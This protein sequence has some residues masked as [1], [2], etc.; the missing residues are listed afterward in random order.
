MKIYLDTSNLEEIHK[1]FT[2]GVVDG[3]TTNPSLIKAERDRIKAKGEPVEMTD[4]LKEI[5]ET[6]GAN[7][8]VSLEVIGSTYDEFVREG[9][10]LFEKFNPVAGNVVVKIPINPV[11]GDET[12]GNV[13]D[14]LKAIHHFS[15]QKVPV[16]CTLIFTP[17]QALLA[18]KAGA[19][20][21]SPFAGRIDDLLRDTYTDNPYAKT[22]YYPMDGFPEQG[23][24]YQDN[25]VVSGVDLVAKTVAV[26]ENYPLETFDGHSP[27][28][29]AAS[30]RNARQA[31]ELALVGADIA[32][33]PFP[34]LEEILAHDKTQ[35]G[36]GKF[37]A[38]VVPEYRSIFG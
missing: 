5:L 32:T 24:C 20:Y 33:L 27:E 19:K 10:L 37:V 38:D 2:L 26:I 8:P 23:V 16:N 29:L 9:E 4:V 1:G 13:Y 31:R 34:V 18:A 17:E 35:E 22:D 11:M 28:V 15:E 25:G 30:V 3:I 12:K 6:A 36:M 21:L 14:G 7:C